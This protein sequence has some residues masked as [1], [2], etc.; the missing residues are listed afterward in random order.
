MN[1]KDAKIIAKTITN[2]QLLQMFTNAKDNIKDWTEKSSVNKLFSKG[3]AWNILA[4]DFDVNTNYHVI[5]KTNMIREFGDFLPEELKPKTTHKEEKKVPLIHQV[6]NF[7][8]YKA[9][10]AVEISTKLEK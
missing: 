3:T 2:K 8:L 7:D 4:S 6:P 9:I 5:S 1:K 10:N